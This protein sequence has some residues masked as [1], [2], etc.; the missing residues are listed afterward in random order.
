MLK[1]LEFDEKG[2]NKRIEA[3]SFKYWKN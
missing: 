1:T 3:R 2:S